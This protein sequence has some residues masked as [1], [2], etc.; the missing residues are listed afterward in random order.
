MIM[1]L[2]GANQKYQGKVQSRPHKSELN[3]PR[4]PIQQHFAGSQ[5]PNPFPIE[6]RQRKAVDFQ[7]MKLKN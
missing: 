5:L 7:N 3:I 1:A 4:H 2:P 6:F